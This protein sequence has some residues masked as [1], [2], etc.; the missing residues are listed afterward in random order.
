MAESSARPNPQVRDRPAGGR[1][2]EPAPE[3]L[4]A[5]SGQANYALAP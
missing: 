4:C 2:V 3:T 1:L 5:G